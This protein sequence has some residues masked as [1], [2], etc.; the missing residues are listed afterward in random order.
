M[1]IS[2]ICRS[3]PAWAI[4]LLGSLT[5]RAAI[6]VP[7]TAMLAGAAAAQSTLPPQTP[8]PVRPWPDGVTASAAAAF[9]IT[10]ETIAFNE[11]LLPEE[12][13]SIAV[14]ES[15]NRS[16]VHI[17][18]R[19]AALDSFLQ[20]KVREGGGSGSVLDKQGMILTNQHVV[21]GARE[22]SVSLFNGLSYS[23]VLVGQ[24]PETDIAILKIDAP[25][26]ELYP[27]K[28][29]DSSGLL[30]G[31]RIYAIGN[32]FGLERTMSTG[33]ISSLNRQ[34]PSGERRTMRSLIQ[35][36]ASINQGNSGGPLLNTRGQLIGMTTAIMS[37]DG[38]SAGVG[39]AI[40]VSTIAR[41]APQ[42]IRDG[43]VV[44]A[45]IG[46]RRVYENEEGLLIVDTVDG[47]PADQAGLQGFRI[48]T[49]TYR[50]GLYRYPL[51]VLD[52]SQADLILA[53]DG[54]RV[55]SADQLLE[56]IEQKRPGDTVML[57]IKR[58]EQQV[59]VTVTLGSS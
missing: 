51:T 13:V 15:C 3:L 40:P 6:C 24:D 39:F 23:A 25:E 11:E 19:S 59:N 55:T 42:L 26:E 27:I 5:S 22:I 29:G 52:T 38:D 14:Y 58:D 36:D 54:Q 16:V 12:R 56:F 43:R 34:I 2:Y 17:S 30:V 44:R 9:A 48:V 53:V 7:A 57:T 18:T 45:S 4:A 33:M 37:S 21:D 47:G 20:V 28:W 49:K 41:I 31:Q 50:Q 1:H 8:T 46:I 35:I 10:P 32:P